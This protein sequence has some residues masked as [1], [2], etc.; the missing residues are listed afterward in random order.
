MV[1]RST[2]EWRR[3]PL[4]AD[5][6]CCYSHPKPFVCKVTPRSPEYAALILATEEANLYV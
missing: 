6:V 2:Y 5:M 4:L 1:S 3:T